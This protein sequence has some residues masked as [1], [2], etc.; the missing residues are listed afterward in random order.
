MDIHATSVLRGP[1]SYRSSDMHAPVRTWILGPGKSHEHSFFVSCS[2]LSLCT[3]SRRPQSQPLTKYARNSK[4]SLFIHLYVDRANEFGVC[5]SQSATELRSENSW[6]IPAATS[7]WLLSLPTSVPL[8]T[9]WAVVNPNHDLWLNTPQTSYKPFTTLEKTSGAF[10]LGFRV[11][12]FLK[13]GVP[14][15]GGV[16]ILWK[17]DNRGFCLVF[18]MK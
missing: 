15:L 14:F 7:D 17:L 4:R 12:S 2:K 3:K 6:T 5:G 13:I 16:M 11:T 10:H 1:C 9:V 8:S 18:K